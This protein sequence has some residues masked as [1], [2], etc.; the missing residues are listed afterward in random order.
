[1]TQPRAPIQS[2]IRFGA[3]EL[4]AAAGELRK[5]GKLARLQPQPFRV[6]AL[7]ASQPGKVISR[8]DLKHEIWNG[9]V[10]VDFDQGL[11]FCIRRIRAALDDDPDSPRFLETVPRRGYRYIADVETVPPDGTR[12]EAQPAVETVRATPKPSAPV[13]VFHGRLAWIAGAALVFAAVGAFMVRW[14]QPATAS[15]LTYFTSDV[16]PLAMILVNS[17]ILFTSAGS[18]SGV[19]RVGSSMLT[20]QKLDE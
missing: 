10:F 11:N 2:V 9:T 3:F 15:S 16:E 5:K 6:L 1:M 4:D 14:R 8:S 12:D 17:S 7:L 13:G 20:K 19:S 18:V